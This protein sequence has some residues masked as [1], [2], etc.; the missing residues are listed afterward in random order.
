M[1]LSPA[2]STRVVPEQASKLQRNPV[3]KDLKKK[4]GGE[5]KSE[6]PNLCC[7]A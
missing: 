1:C 4:G 3:P 2:W 6:L 5:I 7:Q